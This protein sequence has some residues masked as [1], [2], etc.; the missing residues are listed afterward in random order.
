MPRVSS[1]LT[2]TNDIA[3]SGNALAKSSAG[4]HKPSTERIKALTRSVFFVPVVLWQAVQRLFGAPFLSTGIVNSVQSAALLLHNNGGS[5]QNLTEDTTMSND[6]YDI[7]LRLS[8]FEMEAFQ[9]LLLNL[10]EADLSDFTNGN[11]LLAMHARK[12]SQQTIN[13]ISVF[14]GMQ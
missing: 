10:I 6:I 11:E 12:A 9:V 1:Q 3:Y 7:P 14:G 2:M 8:D 13:A 5:F 4:I